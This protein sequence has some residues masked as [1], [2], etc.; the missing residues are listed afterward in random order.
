M[1]HCVLSMECLLRGDFG[2]E[3]FDL[4][5]S[6]LMGVAEVLGNLGCVGWSVRP[7]RALGA[8]DWIR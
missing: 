2:R 5:G 6:A 3:K 1:E 7:V 8:L 4:V